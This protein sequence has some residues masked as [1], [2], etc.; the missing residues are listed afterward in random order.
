[1]KTQI[2]LLLILAAVCMT[3][4]MAG[5]SA[6]LLT[7]DTIAASAVESQKG[8]DALGQA[9]QT[10]DARTQEQVADAVAA[11]VL[12]AMG[13]TL[14]PEDQA[15]LRDAVRQ[16]MR[17]KIA[18]MIEQERRRNELLAAIRDNLDYIQELCR[19]G[20]EFTLYR[21]N[22]DQQWKSYIESTARARMKTVEP[23]TATP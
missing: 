4:C 5:T 3:G 14:T 10:Q 17:T 2:V 15:K 9:V 12:K 7:Y 18:D 22:I 19:Q 13:K 6:E 11:T 23:T 1:M 16:E 20:K 8:V 21:A